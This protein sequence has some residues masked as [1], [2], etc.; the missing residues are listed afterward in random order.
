MSLPGNVASPPRK[1]KSWSANVESLPRNIVNLPMNVA[2]P[3]GNV[4]SRVL[5]AIGFSAASASDCRYF[6][7]SYPTHQIGNAL[8]LPKPCLVTVTNLKL[9]GHS[10]CFRGYSMTSFCYN[11]GEI[12]NGLCFTKRSIV[13]K[14]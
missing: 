2:N 11:R 1:V 5:E 3:P 13:T 9:N 10:F 12:K 8:P 4:A 7:R 14:I 6:I